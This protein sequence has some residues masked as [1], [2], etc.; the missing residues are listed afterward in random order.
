MLNQTAVDLEEP[1]GADQ[2]A[3]ADAE[4]GTARPPDRQ[5]AIETSIWTATCDML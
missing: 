4:R 2:K 1:V 5:H 3:S